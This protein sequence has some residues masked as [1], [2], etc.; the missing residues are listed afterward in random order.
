MER[1]VESSPAVAVL[2]LSVS[3]FVLLLAALVVIGTQTIATDA[4]YGTRVA[5][6]LWVVMPLLAVAALLS[7]AA[8]RQARR[9]GVAV[10]WV[11]LI[12]AVMWA[13]GGLA[14]APVAFVILIVLFSGFLFVTFELR[15]LVG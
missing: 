6:L 2:L 13:A 10:T 7:G 8:M 1:E 5:W 4:V 12:S 14:L 9:H 11:R 15:Q 3:G